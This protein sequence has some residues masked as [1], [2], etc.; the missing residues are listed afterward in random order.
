ML[1]HFSRTPAKKKSSVAPG[2]LVTSSVYWSCSISFSFFF[3][4]SFS[5]SFWNTFAPPT[6]CF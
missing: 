3:P 6:L 5:F 2:I 1:Q 4:I